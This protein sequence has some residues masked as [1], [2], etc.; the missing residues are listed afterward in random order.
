MRGVSR[1][2]MLVGVLAVATMAGLNLMKEDSKLKTKLASLKESI[3][4]KV[5][6][7]DCRDVGDEDNS[8]SVLH[9]ISMLES[10]ELLGEAIGT[11][12]FSLSV[13]DIN[14]DGKDDILVGAHERNTSILIQTV[15]SQINPQHS[16]MHL[17]R[18][19]VMATL[20]PTW[21]TMAIW[22]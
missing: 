15:G 9:P 14:A 10:S 12:T 16:L 5:F 4:A 13:A 19:I 22:I 17:I 18:T 11:K 1:K 3:Y 2:I 6:Q 21:I 7:P 20:L 8:T